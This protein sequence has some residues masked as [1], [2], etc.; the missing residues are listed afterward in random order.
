MARHKP[1]CLD[2]KSSS[3]FPLHSWVLP[4][5][6]EAV[7]IWPVLPWLEG[8]RDNDVSCPTTSSSSVN[9][10]IIEIPVIY[11]FHS[12]S[13]VV[14][15]ELFGKI[16]LLH[17]SRRIITFIPDFPYLS[18][19]L[20]VIR[21]RSCQSFYTS[22]F[23]VST[24][25]ARLR[26]AKDGI[27]CRGFLNVG[28]PSSGLS[29]V[30]VFPAGWSPEDSRSARSSSPLLARG[31]FLSL[32]SWG[33]WLLVWQPQYG[34]LFLLFGAFLSSRIQ[35][36]SGGLEMGDNGSCHIECVLARPCWMEG[37]L[38]VRRGEGTWYRAWRTSS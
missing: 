9:F 14:G 30:Q 15:G 24:P 6:A 38:G 13:R 23:W 12:H 16:F 4:W 7:L 37:W 20:L 8:P 10:R 2:Y 22:V 11:F 21:G 34:S 26:V 18:F 32:A 1:S 27:P 35:H 29:L 36:Q 31:A 33:L 25:G 17:P 28:G 19:P 3:L 5:E